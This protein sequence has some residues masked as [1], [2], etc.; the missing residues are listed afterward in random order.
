MEFKLQ[1][2]SSDYPFVFVGPVLVPDTMKRVDVLP[3][4]TELPVCNA[5]RAVSTAPRRPGGGARAR[6]AGPTGTAHPAGPAWASRPHG[7]GRCGHGEDVGFAAGRSPGPGEAPPGPRER[8]GAARAEEMDSLEVALHGQ[9]RARPSLGRVLLSH[10]L[11]QRGV[12]VLQLLMESSVEFV[13]EGGVAGSRGALC[14]EEVEDLL[15][16]LVEDRDG[17]GLPELAAIHLP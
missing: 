3:A 1:P 16:H 10:H 6:R 12:Q 8:V 4:F 15:E 13:Q 2:I 7:L 11:H 5:R 9:C 14:V 17:L